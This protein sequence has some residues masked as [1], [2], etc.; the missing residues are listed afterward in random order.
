MSGFVEETT[1]IDDC[2]SLAARSLGFPWNA[3]SRRVGVEDALYARSAEDMIAPEPYPPFTRSLRDGYALNHAASV[4]ASAS[5][6]VFLSL[7]GEIYMGESPSFELAS[8]EAASIPTGGMLP[9][10][11]DSVVMA[12]N[13]SVSGGWVE[14]RSSVQRGLNVMTAAEEIARGDV[15]LRRGETISESTPGLLATF[16]ITAVNVM[17]IRAGLIATGDEIVPAGASP[18]PTG[19]IRDANTFIIQ[20]A[21][22]RYGIESTSYGI[23]QDAWDALKPASEAALRECD[24]VLISGGSSV[25]AK[26]H[27]A[28]LIDC[29]SDRGLLARGL[30]MIPGKP[31]IIGGSRDAKKLIVGLPG[32]PLS[33]MAAT[34]FVALPLINAMYGTIGGVGKYCAL[35]LSEDVSGHSGPDEFIPAKVGLDGVRPLAAKSGYVSAMRDADGFIRL[36]PDTET[37]RKGEMAEVWLW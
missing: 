5:S 32:H 25:G 3:K 29:L 14:I 19:F 16:G 36:R 37:K 13:T 24:V 18:L 1:S 27:A 35:P 26:D 17:D 10:G 2:L 9:R 12:E 6:P 21:L 34:I 4:G 15:L 20:S 8:G 33:C 11:A 7:A 23:A 30:N 28:R 31:T 22:K